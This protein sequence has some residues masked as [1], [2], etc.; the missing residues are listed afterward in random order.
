MVNFLS[1]EFTI[2][3]LQPVTLGLYSKTQPQSELSVCQAS[4]ERKS[5]LISGG[6]S[7]DSWV[8]V[9]ALDLFVKGEA[10]GCT[11]G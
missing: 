4:E 8:L 2:V 10:A 7:G 11:T 9:R 6:D 3:Y 1:S 5:S